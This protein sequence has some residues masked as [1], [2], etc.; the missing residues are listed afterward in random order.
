SLDYTYIGQL[1]INVA[2]CAPLVLKPQVYNVNF[3]QTLTAPATGVPSLFS[4]GSG[5]NRRIQGPADPNPSDTASTYGNAAIAYGAG[6][7]FTYTPGLTP[8]S[9]TDEF[10]YSVIDQC[11]NEASESAIVN[12]NP[13]ITP[14]T[15]NIVGGSATS[16]N[17]LANDKGVDPA[18]VNIDTTAA[19]GATITPTTGGNFTYNRKSGFDGVDTFKYR[20]KDLSGEVAYTGTATVNVANSATPPGPPS[21]V[22]ATP[23]NGEA[24]VRWGAPVNT[25]GNT[26]E[27]V[28][29]RGST[30]RVLPSTT[31]QTTFEPLA[32]GTTY[33]FSVRTRSGAGSSSAVSDTATPRTVPG[34]PTSVRASV[35]GSNITVSWNG[36]SNGGASITKSK[37][38][39]S[40][41]R[42]V[43]VAGS[44]R[45]ARFTGMK[46]GSY[47]F[48]VRS[49]NVAG[50]GAI[51]S[52]SSSVIVAQSSP[53]YVARYTEAEYQYLVK[54]ARHFGLSVNEVAKTGVAVIRFILA[55][56]PHPPTRAAARPQ[57]SGPRLTT[58]TYSVTTNASTMVPVSRYLVL[59]GNDTLKVGAA[60]MQYFAA[61][62]GVR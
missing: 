11:G 36:P 30:T 59:N 54:T 46:P 53:T 28:V 39:A 20:V 29:T 27:Y 52:R 37:V 12:V 6:G 56:A 55:I 33:T 57:N 10:S 60:L 13:V 5:T 25:G 41:G 9:G 49:Q 50:W 8:F 42:V 38:T 45:S 23:G 16:G 4:G 7:A 2:G 58:A 22:V 3:G 44:G 48:T 21:F 32:N 47:T 24:T 17:V 34:K 43:Y 14:D 18:T 35:S 51:S 61:L 31:T 19:S 40:N 62:Q 15:F 1:S 26:I